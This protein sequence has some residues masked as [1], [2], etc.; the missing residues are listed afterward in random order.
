MAKLQLN[1]D[2]TEELV[3]CLKIRE[4]KLPA[5]DRDIG[6][7]HAYLAVAREFCA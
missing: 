6:E 2:A 1:R 7:A 3:R 5:G 4:S